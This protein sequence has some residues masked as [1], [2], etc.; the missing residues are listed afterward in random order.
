MNELLI[1]I[2]FL[3]AV[4]NSLALFGVSFTLYRVSRELRKRVRRRRRPLRV[5][6]TV[7]GTENKS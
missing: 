1:L 5:R 3:V 2:A 6:L 4:T 7:E